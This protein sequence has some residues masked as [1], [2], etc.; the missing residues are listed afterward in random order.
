MRAL[1]LLAASLIDR[2]DLWRRTA[3]LVRLLAP[4]C[5]IEA[6]ATSRWPPATTDG[7]RRLSEL[8]IL[9]TVVRVAGCICWRCS[10]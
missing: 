1:T 3:L 4:L 9:N 7:F 2:S 5:L 10:G 6:L 8:E